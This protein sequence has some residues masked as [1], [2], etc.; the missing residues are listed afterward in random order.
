MV[1]LFLGGYSEMAKT[2]AYNLL[3]EDIAIVNLL[4]V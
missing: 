4:L 3:L 1:T 2:C